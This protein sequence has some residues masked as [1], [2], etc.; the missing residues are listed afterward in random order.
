MKL[1]RMQRVAHV[2][3]GLLAADS[4]GGAGDVS[5]EGEPRGLGERAD[6]AHLRAE[7]LVPHR[8]PSILEIDPD[9]HDASNSDRVPC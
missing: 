1:H 3:G 6:A 5:V 8:S 4:G 2:V 7:V 9:M